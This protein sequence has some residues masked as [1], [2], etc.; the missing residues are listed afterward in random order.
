[1]KCFTSRR[2]LNYL[3][4]ILPTVIAFSCVTQAAQGQSQ[5]KLESPGS[6]DS[7][8]VQGSSTRNLEVPPVL[9]APRLG[10]QID[11]NIELFTSEGEP[12]VVKPMSPED[13]QLAPGLEAP[14]GMPDEIV[15][16]EPEQPLLPEVE[17]AM[18]ELGEYRPTA[19]LLGTQN[20]PRPQLGV[21]GELVR[22]WGFKIVEVIPGS[23]AARMQLERGD[24]ILNINGQ[25]VSSISSIEQQLSRSAGEFGGQGVIKIDNI[26][27]RTRC[28]TSSKRF[29]WLKF[30][31]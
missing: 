14:G 12:V 22:G 27:G 1:M 5:P 18:P 17:Q 20:L 8:G 16:V 3:S 23:V 4:A 13:L 7:S 29:L 10:D 15:V 2:G 19:P 24:V 11:S 21:A 9:E 28:G 31:L 30:Q 6:V 25:C 26:R